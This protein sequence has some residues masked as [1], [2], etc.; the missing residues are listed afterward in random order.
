MSASANCSRALAA[1]ALVGLLSITRGTPLRRV[2]YTARVRPPAVSDSSFRALMALFSGVHLDA[3][4][5]FRL[6]DTTARG[7]EHAAA[8]D[9]HAAPAARLA[10]PRQPVGERGQERTQEDLIP[11]R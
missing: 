3:D 6:G 9:H 11:K 10:A 5:Q 2:L 7:Q 1:L 8:A 4:E